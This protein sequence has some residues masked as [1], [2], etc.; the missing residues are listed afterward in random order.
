MT[1]RSAVGPGFFGDG[2]TNGEC[3]DERDDQ[4]NEGIDIL[5]ISFVASFLW[6]LHSLDR[7]SLIGKFDFDRPISPCPIGSHYSIP[8]SPKCLDFPC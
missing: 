6:L 7:H 1:G 3:N 4:E 5:L 2:L 8:H